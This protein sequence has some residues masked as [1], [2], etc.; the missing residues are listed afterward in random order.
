MFDSAQSTCVTDE[1]R[2]CV[3]CCVHCELASCAKNAIKSSLAQ[4]KTMRHIYQFYQ[5]RAST[6]CSCRRGR[7]NQ[8]HTIT[9]SINSAALQLNVALQPTIYRTARCRRR[10]LPPFAFAGDIRTA[11]SISR[12]TH[13]TFSLVKM[14]LQTHD[15]KDWFCYSCMQQEAQLSQKNQRVTDQTVTIENNY[16]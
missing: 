10:L 7:S 14:S 4:I 11:L 9:A 8:L 5:G 13:Q 12:R 2:C 6:E 3:L 16:I 1:L 15:K